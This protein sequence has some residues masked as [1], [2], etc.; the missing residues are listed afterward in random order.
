MGVSL[1]IKIRDQ[2]C[3]RRLMKNKKVTFT[4]SESLFV[5]GLLD[6][7]D[8]LDSWRMVTGLT[9]PRLNLTSLC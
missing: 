9:L 8:A 1:R 3:H 2:I 6:S 7:L 4:D 5:S